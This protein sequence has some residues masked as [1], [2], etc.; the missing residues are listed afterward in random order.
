MPVLDMSA[1]PA[2]ERSNKQPRKAEQ[3]IVNPNGTLRN[4]FVWIKSGLPP[5]VWAP[6]AEVAK[7]DQIGCVYEP[8]VLGLMVGQ[9]LEISNS[10]TVNHNVH[11]ESKVNEGWSESEAPRSEKKI[12]RFD[13]PEVMFPLSCGVHSWMKSYIGVSPHP[14]FFVTGDDGAFTLNGVP[15]GTYTIEAVHERYGRTESVITVAAKEAKSVDFQ[16]NAG[17]SQ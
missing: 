3:V 4:A 17:A 8:H 13:K 16:F 12:K 9:T 6:P 7:V 10:D 5:A 14:F 15:P 11:A 2:C 1:N